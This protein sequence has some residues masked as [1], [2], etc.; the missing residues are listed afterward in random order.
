MLNRRNFLWAAFSPGV[1]SLQ[2]MLGHFD[3]ISASLAKE[4]ER[5]ENI[6]S[7][8]AAPVDR[9]PV[10]DAPGSGVSGHLLGECLTA[11]KQ[12]GMRL[13]ARMTTDLN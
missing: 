5:V 3:V 2:P 13:V 12:H 11:A 4:V 7:V 8:P 9:G 1:I 6:V 10:D